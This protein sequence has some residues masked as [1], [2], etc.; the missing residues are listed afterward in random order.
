[1]IL[2][3]RSA[4]FNGFIVGCCFFLAL[5]FIREG[6]ASVSVGKLV[7]AMLLLVFVLYRF[8]VAQCAP[9]IVIEGRRKKAR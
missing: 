4:W 7:A 9:V 2:N 1:M 3:V 6:I 5:A 8:I